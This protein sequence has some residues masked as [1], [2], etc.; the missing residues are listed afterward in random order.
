MNGNSKIK[1]TTGTVN[2]QEEGNLS[3]DS[4]ISVYTNQKVFNGAIK[5]IKDVNKKYEKKNKSTQE[6]SDSN[7]NQNI[8]KSNSFI[9]NSG[10]KTSLNN[11]NQISENDVNNKRE[12]TSSP[13]NVNRNK[14]QNKKSFPGLNFNNLSIKDVCEAVKEVKRIPSENMNVENLENNQPEGLVNPPLSFRPSEDNNQFTSEPSVTNKT[15]TEKSGIIIKSNS[16]T[17]TLKNKNPKESLEKNIQNIQQ[18][19]SVDKVKMETTLLKNILSTEEEDAQVFS[20]ENPLNEDNCFWN[21]SRRDEESSADSKRTKETKIIS[22]EQSRDIICNNISLTNSGRLN[23]IHS[24]FNYKTQTTS[25]VTCTVSKIEKGLAV[26]VSSDDN[27]FSLPISFLPKNVTPGNS[28]NITVDET[29][30]LQKKVN[31]LQK[32]HLKYIKNNNN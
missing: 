4:E 15:I 18:N 11:L 22:S 6:P 2:S 27:I 20:P 24:K 12:K 26:L 32:I 14:I 3:D 5:K 25:Q 30:K 28:Y 8:P 19:A 13:K 10:K 31:S 17:P 16:Q 9:N 29:I 1:A 21:M 23:S 7:G